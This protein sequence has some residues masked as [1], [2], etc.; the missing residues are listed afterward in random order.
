MATPAFHYQDPFP[1]G[2]DETKYRLLTKEG[3]SGAAFEGKEIV[4]GR[5][6]PGRNDP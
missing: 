6:F 4:D 5:L 2:K 1:L 3:V